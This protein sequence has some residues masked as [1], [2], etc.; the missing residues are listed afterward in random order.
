MQRRKR[1]EKFSQIRRSS[2][3]GILAHSRRRDWQN[4]SKFLWDLAQALASKIAQTE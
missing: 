2:W 1:L 4:D 3:T